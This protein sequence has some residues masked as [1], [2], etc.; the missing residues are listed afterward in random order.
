MGN[1]P[2]E[3]AKSEEVSSFVRSLESENL[4]GFTGYKP[5][6]LEGLSG[7]VSRYNVVLPK[8]SQLVEDIELSLSSEE[9]GIE[10]IR[11]VRD[12]RSTTGLDSISFC[13]Y[14]FSHKDWKDCGYYATRDWVDEEGSFAAIS[15]LFDEAKVQI[16]GRAAFSTIESVDKES[17][18]DILKKINDNGFYISLLSE[19]AKEFEDLE[20][21]RALDRFTEGAVKVIDFVHEHSL[22]EKLLEKPNEVVDELANELLW[23]LRFLEQNEIFTLKPQ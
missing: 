2:P 19:G 20:V 16:W 11:F 7:F 23:V 22:E 10:R 9:E 13:D 17:W 6:E 15:F 12:G 21:E 8:A 14:T 4:V 3:I 5:E 18:E 1:I